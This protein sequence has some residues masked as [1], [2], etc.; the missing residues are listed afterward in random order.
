MAYLAPATTDSLNFL[1][2]SPGS[3][4]APSY[5]DR[6]RDKTGARRRPDLTCLALSEGLV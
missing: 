1:R 2:S 3:V 6:I 5:L 4:P